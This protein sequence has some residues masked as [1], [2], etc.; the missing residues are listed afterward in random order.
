LARAAPA[1]P[2]LAFQK[3]REKQWQL[4]WDLESPSDSRRRTL[5]EALFTGSSWI[6][7]P[8]LSVFASLSI[9]VGVALA[10][11]PGFRGIRDR[12]RLHGLRR[13]DPN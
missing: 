5:S 8:I 11:F 13:L 6:R 7:H 10:S 2:A 4:R 12:R 1:K 3:A 9:G